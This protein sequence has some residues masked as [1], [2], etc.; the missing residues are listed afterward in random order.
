[1]PA[2]LLLVVAG[3]GD[4]PYRAAVDAFAAGSVGEEETIG[5]VVSI[6]AGSRFNIQ[7]GNHRPHAHGFAAGGDESV[8]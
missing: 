6:G 2:A 5:P 1:M 3:L 8:A 7:P 4:G